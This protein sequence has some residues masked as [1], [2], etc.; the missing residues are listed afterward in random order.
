VK[1]L[2]DGEE[3][4]INLDAT[5]QN[6]IILALTRATQIA[7][8]S[9]AGGIITREKEWL[10]SLLDQL[11][12]EARKTLEKYLD[13]SGL[14][15]FVRCSMTRKLLASDKP[16]PKGLSKLIDHEEFS[17][18]LSVAKA[19]CA[20][21][22]SLP[23]QYQILLRG[24]TALARKLKG[25][26]FNVKVS[27][28]LSLVS[29]DQISE[30]LPF[31]HDVEQIDSWLRARSSSSRQP[32]HL[33]EE[34]IYFVY[35]ASGFV[36]ER[37][38]SKLV[39]AAS[40]EVRSFFGACIAMDILW[41]DYFEFD[42]TPDEVGSVVFVHRMDNGP[43]LASLEVADTDVQRATQFDTSS[44]TDN[45]LGS[46]VPIEE[47][48]STVKK[49][50]DSSESPRLSTASA[51]LLRTHLSS[52][53]IDRVLESTIT[54]EVLL[55]DREASD[56]VGLSKLMANRCAY[57][58]A[59]SQ[60]ERKNIMDFFVKFYKL[61]SDIVHTG[62]FNPSELEKGIVDRGVDLATRILRHEISMST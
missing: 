37:I 11:T 43:E 1:Y 32:Q 60:N 35:R 10:N 17:D 23:W 13:D 58:L 62:K 19:L 20:T 46:G 16:K 5:N 44:S 9:P 12:P 28:Q 50:S 27:N 3:M 22:E 31:S 55:G 52:A 61:R 33:D 15:G 34:H 54:M 26:S 2:P 57:S 59:T 18:P 21:I 53:D 14:A 8:A 6:A 42:Y 36:D 24:P 51:W 41:G 45:K 25:I 39:R 56:R 4:A 7:K 49:I 40:D 30:D 38:N 29:A 48:L 47:I